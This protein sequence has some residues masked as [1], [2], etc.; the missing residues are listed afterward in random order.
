MPRQALEY[1]WPNSGYS[2]LREATMELNKLSAER[3]SYY[4][5]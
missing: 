5:L 3:I 1:I 2:P 4:R